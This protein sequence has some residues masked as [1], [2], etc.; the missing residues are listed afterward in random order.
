MGGSDEAHNTIN[1]RNYGR[2]SGVSIGLQLRWVGLFW[3]F[4]VALTIF[5]ISQL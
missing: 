3:G 2:H 1:V 5:V 4:Y